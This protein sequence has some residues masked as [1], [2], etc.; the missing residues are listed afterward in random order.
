MYVSYLKTILK[1]ALS[2]LLAFL[3]LVSSSGFSINR[4][5]CGDKLKSTDV[6][7]IQNTQSCCGKKAMPKGCCK[8]ETQVIKIN[9]KFTPT[10]TVN[11]P[12]TDFIAVFFVAFI[13]TFDFSLS[14]SQTSNLQ[15]GS[16][17]PPGKTVSRTILF[18]SILI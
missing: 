16:H 3:F 8:N 10:Q 5:Y 6:L 13:Q 1:K 17:A 9:E 2:I 12:S 18:R 4:H 11:I 15:T 7:L 14:D